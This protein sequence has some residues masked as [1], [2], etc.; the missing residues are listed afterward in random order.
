MSPLKLRWVALFAVLLMS[1][2]G[3]SSV[4]HTP[5]LVGSDTTVPLSDVHCRG[6]NLLVWH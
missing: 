6:S 1:S 4:Y 3:Q 2:N 5:M